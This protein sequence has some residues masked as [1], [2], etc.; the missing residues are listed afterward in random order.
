MVS[1]DSE[2]VSSLCCLV[3]SIYWLVA[4]GMN[5]WAL[6][7]FFSHPA[8][9]P[10]SFGGGASE[11]LFPKPALMPGRAHSPTV[12]FLTSPSGKPGSSPPLFRCWN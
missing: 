11:S 2:P 1:E 7:V 12:F 10:D 9:W 3:W 4:D 8:D 6:R 5:S